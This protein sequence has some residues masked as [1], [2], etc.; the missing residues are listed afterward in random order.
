ML[1]RLEQNYRSTRP[2]LEVANAVIS[3]NSARKGKELWTAKE[4]GAPVRVNTLLDEE[5]EAEFVAR[6]IKSQ[7]SLGV[8]LGGFAVLY[9]T[10]AQSRALEAALARYRLPYQIVGGTRFYDRKEVRDLLAYL[11]VIANPADG[12]SLLRILNLPPRGIGKTTVGRF[13][14]L[15]ERHGL[16]PGILLTGFPELLDED[17]FAKLG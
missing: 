3:N 4:S 8:A 6:R 13:L 12:V 7:S 10:H 15:A 9:R 17:T 1:I 11:K 5:D 14:D 16:A 2:I